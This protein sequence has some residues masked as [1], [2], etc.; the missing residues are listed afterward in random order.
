MES[1]RRHE[2]GGRIVGFFKGS[3][4]AI[5]LFILIAILG[6]LGRNFIVLPSPSDYA[7]KV[8]LT[9]LADAYAKKFDHIQDKKL[10]KAEY[11]T[12]HRALKDT[13]MTDLNSIK[14]DA[15]ENKDMLRKILIMHMS[16]KND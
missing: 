3:G 13:I 5:T 6:Y 4:K 2:V 11:E 15:K 7:Q 1:G 10:D 12:N 8:E 16:K 9:A 14:N